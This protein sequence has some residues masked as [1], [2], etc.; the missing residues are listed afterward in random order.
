MPRIAYLGLFMVVAA[1]P[2]IFFAALSQ[3]PGSGNYNNSYDRGNHYRRGPSFFFYN[4][5][6]SRYR[7]SGRSYSSGGYKG[8]GFRSGK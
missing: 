1:I 4:S 7:S 8:G 3:P 6:G 2:F 5:G